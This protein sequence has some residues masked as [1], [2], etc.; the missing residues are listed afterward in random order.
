MYAVTPTGTEVHATVANSKTIPGGDAVTLVG[1]DESKLDDEPKQHAPVRVEAV[2]E[3]LP[4][5][6]LA[7]VI[8]QVHHV[9]AVEPLALLH[10]RFRPDH[11]LR[12][13]QLDRNP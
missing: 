10:E 11:F 1:I 5:E 4:V 6:S 2:H 8:D 13:A 3:P 12:R 7:E 9:G